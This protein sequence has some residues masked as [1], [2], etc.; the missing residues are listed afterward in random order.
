LNL[1]R[2]SAPAAGAI[3]STAGSAAT[4][5]TK[6]PAKSLGEKELA[7]QKAEFNT[8]SQK[9]KLLKRKRRINGDNRARKFG[10]LS[11]FAATLGAESDC[12]DELIDGRAD[13]LGRAPT[14]DL[15]DRSDNRFGPFRD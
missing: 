2:L 9:R 13:L 3:S 15:Q 6:I 10:R 4:A 5:L 7:P 8:T 1:K 14:G 12:R 11:R